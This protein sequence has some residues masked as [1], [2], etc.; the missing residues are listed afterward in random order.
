[1]NNKERAAEAAKN[2]EQR[3]KEI[4]GNKYDY[5]QINYINNSTAMKIICPIHGVFEQTPQ[6]HLRGHGC[7]KN[8]KSGIK[9]TKEEFIK[10][11]KE[12]HGNKYNYSKT[13]YI[14]SHKKIKIVC[15]KHGIFEQTPNSHLKGKGCKKCGREIFANSIKKSTDIFKQEAKEIHNNKYDYSLITD[16]KNVDSKVKIICPFHGIFEQRVSNHLRGIGCPY[17]IKNYGEEKIKKWLDFNNFSYFRSH[18]FD[19]LKDKGQL[20]YDFYIP[21]KNLLIEYNGEQHY[22]FINYFYKTLH[23]FHKQKHHDWLKRKYA[24]DHNIKLLTIPYWDYKIINEIL[25]EDVL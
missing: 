15:P 22:K 10:R 20:S 7:K 25:E 2:F 11:A 3:A 21:S 8:K 24:K 16:Y 1:M 5:S 6:H 9:L 14:N 19:D 12:I 18:K 4:H 23:D 17:C 13:E